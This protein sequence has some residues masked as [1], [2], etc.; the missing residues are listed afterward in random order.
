MEETIET[1]FGIALVAFAA[2]LLLPRTTYFSDNIM[3]YSFEA[4]SCNQYNVCNVERLFPPLKLRVDS[5]KSQVIWLDQS[6][7]SLGTW[8]ECT[9]SDKENWFCSNPTMTMVK[10]YLQSNNANVQHPAG[11]VYRLY[12]LLSFLPSR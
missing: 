3:I 6:N 1:A 8:A 2:W 9:I 4:S 12:W 7:G 5:Q 10:G 11:F